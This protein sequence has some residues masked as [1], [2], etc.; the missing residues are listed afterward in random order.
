MRGTIDM[1]DA[2]IE[3]LG[4]IEPAI[5]IPGHDRCAQ[6]IGSGLSTD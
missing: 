1:D 2:G 5:L 4:Q 3:P 6:A